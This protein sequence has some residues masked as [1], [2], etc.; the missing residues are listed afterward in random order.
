MFKTGIK[1]IDID[2][3][4][5]K[6]KQAKDSSIMLNFFEVTKKLMNRTMFSDMNISQRVDISFVDS[7][8]LPLMV[9]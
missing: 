6:C 5:R 9:Q 8:M 4:E 1:N 7:D 2:L 3:M